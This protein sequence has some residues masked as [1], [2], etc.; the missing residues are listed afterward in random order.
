MTLKEQ[1]ISELNKENYLSDRELADRIYGTNAPQ[2]TV[3][4]ACRQLV[5]S[6]RLK[7]TSPPI[8]N[9]I[10]AILKVNL[11]R[12]STVDPIEIPFQPTNQIV[13]VQANT[14]GAKPKYLRNEFNIFWNSFWKTSGRDYFSEMPLDRLVQ[15]KMAV[16]NINN[17]ITHEI[18]MR[19][20]QIIGGIL[21][22]NDVEIA[23]TLNAI[24]STSTNSNGYDIECIGNP[25]Y[26][27]EVKANLPVYGTTF[28][29]A[30]RQQIVKDIWGLI[31]GKTKS[32][33]R[34]EQLGQYYKFLCM[35]QEN[36]NVI[37]AVNSLISGL[38]NQVKQKVKLYQ[39]KE[40]ITFDSVYI[41]F[42]RLHDDTGNEQ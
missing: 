21:E 10:A 42:V 5:T 37:K 38:E 24:E 35:Y 32:I 41:I 22:Q 34:S 26:I 15:L 11:E 8:K 4:Q 27:C 2:Q 20:A 19:A 14:A 12:T 25:S 7:R 36:E 23:H 30:Q 9:Y 31:N 18:T 40:N 17:L 1:I 33:I 16:T 13:K 28:G 39:P 3:N 29:A 6:G